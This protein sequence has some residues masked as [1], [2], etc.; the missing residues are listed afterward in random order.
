MLLTIGISVSVDIID[1]AVL[2]FS[3]ESHCA[4]HTLGQILLALYT[5][6]NFNVNLK[7]AVYIVPLVC[8]FH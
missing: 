1:A 4:I 3:A 6:N 5:Y 8:Y 7:T 2:L